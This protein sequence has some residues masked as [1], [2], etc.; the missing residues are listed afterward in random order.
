MTTFLTKKTNL[1]TRKPLSSTRLTISKLNEVK[2]H[3]HNVSGALFVFP[4][5]AR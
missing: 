5:Q 4:E 2:D 3:D 1:A